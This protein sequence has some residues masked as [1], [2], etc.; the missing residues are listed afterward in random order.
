MIWITCVCVVCLGICLPLFLHYK[1]NLHLLLATGYKCTGTL[2]AFLLALIAGIRLDPRCY[3]CAAAFFLYA[4]ADGFLEY[5]FM[6]GAGFFLVGHICGIAFFLS[7]ASLSALHVISF[8]ASGGMMAY[9]YV[10]WRK[11]I[12]NQ[13]PVFIVYG[14]SLILM[15]SAAIGC[16]SSFDLSGILFAVGG[17]LFL[18]S[19][20][21]LLRR[22]L[23]PL[24]AFYNWVIMSTYYAALLCIG[25]GCLQM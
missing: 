10:R 21:V 6:L 9:V 15:C 18:F 13:M 19:D 11:P 7:T 14:L 22:L 25:I 4:V 1:Q 23:F 20:C 17:M 3:V 8:L 12:G 5:S 2:C 16:F 24:S